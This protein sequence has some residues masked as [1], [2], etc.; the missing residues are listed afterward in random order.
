MS[1]WL[2]QPFVSGPRDGVADACGAVESNL[3]PNDVP[4]TFPALS[5]QFPLRLAVAL[6]GLE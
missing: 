1:V 4:A 3:K 6:S 2:N 5:R